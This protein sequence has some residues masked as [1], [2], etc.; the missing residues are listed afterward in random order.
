M[1]I[2]LTSTGLENQK[3]ANCF[4][5]SFLPKELKDLSFLIVSIQETENH[6]FYLE[7]FLDKI[8]SMGVLDIDVFKLGNKKF[9]PQKDYDVVFVCG[10]NTFDYLDRIRKT[11]LDNFLKDFFNKEDG[12][13]VGISAGSIVVGP[14]ISIA[15]WGSEGD[16]NNINLKDLKGLGLIEFLVYPHYREDLK[17][18]VDEF[19]EK[20]GLKIIRLKDDQAFVLNYSKAGKGVFNFHYINKEI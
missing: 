9:V 3:I 4:E 7:K 15:G 2:F 20:T 5:T 17:E 14:D 10:G 16:E 1:K 11:G 13:Y 19:R 18:E 6:A 12:V 8:K